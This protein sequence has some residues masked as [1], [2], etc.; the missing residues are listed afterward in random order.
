MSI[1]VTG[2]MGL[3]IPA[4][5]EEELERLMKETAGQGISTSADDNLVPQISVL[6]PLSPEVLDGPAKIEGAK[7]GDFLVTDRAIDGREGIWFQPCHQGHI[8][9]EFTPLSQGGGF[10]A[11]YEFTGEDSLPPGAQRREKNQFFMPN[12]NQVIHYRQWAGILWDDGI[13]LEKVISFK[14]TGHT[15]AKEWMT[16]ANQSNRF[17]NGESRSLPAHIY[18]L[19]TSMRRNQSGQWYIINVGDAILITSAEGQRVVQ[20]PARA[21]NM[22]MSLLKAFAG[23]EKRAATV[24]PETAQDRSAPQQEYGRERYGQEEEIP[25]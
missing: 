13:G 6:Q 4:E 10:V 22:G 25:F 5:E 2:Q 15:V 11:A 9:L 20:H 12:G 1:D 17:S 16:K 18:K 14:S 19:T 8:W 23:Q 3:P 21:Y 7:A 24:A